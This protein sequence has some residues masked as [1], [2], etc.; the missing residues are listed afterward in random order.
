MDMHLK[1]NYTMSFRQKLYLS[2]TAIFTV[3]TLLVLIFQ[4]D[5]EK[6]FRIGQLE[7]TLD[8]ISEIAHNYMISNSI[9][10]SGN[11]RMMD[12]LMGIM[13]AMNVRLTVISP[14][15]VVLYDSE[16]SDYNTM[17][18]HLERPEVR[19]SVAKGSGG[20]IRESATT[21]KSYYYY[22]KFYPDYFV[23]TATLYD[24]RVKDFLHVEKLFVFYLALL[25][26]VTAILLYYMTRR[27]SQTI[28]KLKDFTIRL[29]TGQEIDE[30]LQFPK[31]ELG[32]IS[33]QIT[34]LY[35][36]F[37]EARKKLVIEKNKLYSHLSALNEGIAFFSPRKEKVLANNHFIQNLNLLS[38]RS[39]ISAEKIFEEP[40][41]EPILQFIDSH[42][43]DAGVFNTDPLPQMELDLQKGNRYFNVKCAFFQDKSFEIVIADVSK[44]EKRRL[45]KQQMTSNIAHELKTPVATVLGYLETLQHNSITPEKKGYF[46]EKAH[47]QARRLSDL[48]ED[49]STLNKIEEAGDN[50]DF[51][52]VLLAE[53]V[54]EVEEQLKLKLDEQHIKVH[55]DLPKKLEI[56]GN[57][58]LLFSIFYN[59]FDN[60]IKYG[61]DHCE[62][63]LSNYLKDKKNYYFSFANTGTGIEEKH[64]NRIFERFYRIDDGRSR[65]NGGTGLG[66]AI[67]KNAIQLH[68]GEISARQYKD[69]GVEF[70]FS[71]RR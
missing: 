57:K 14:R 65:K 35:R 18:N 37:N 15:G 26:M 40:D 62:I 46:I 41:L 55:I 6:N 20:N 50:Y 32:T 2:F 47:A 30:S 36:D 70:L 67:V 54:S 58:S 13:P 11:F 4:F 53:V 68:N 12:S 29:R 10:E 1:N 39:T 22:A 66:L 43:K 25:F 24:L 69:G 42:L 17:E 48:I 71:L 51:K 7:N 61:G 23:R 60:V 19:E 45:M 59:L 56:R 8:N 5:R 28:N 44:L 38:E 27:F 34:S 31:D 21:G 49:I 33:S 9:P 64:L 63:F 3:F 16:V 52:A